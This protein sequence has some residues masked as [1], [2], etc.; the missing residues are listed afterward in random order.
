VLLPLFLLALFGFAIAF[1][2]LFSAETTE[3]ARALSRDLGLLATLA[4][5]A[6]L[7]GLLGTVMGLIRTFR[8]VGSKAADP[9]RVAAGI[10]EALVATEAGLLV[11]L[12][13]VLFFDRLRARAER[14]AAKKARRAE[15][16]EKRHGS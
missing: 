9:A 4:S 1:R 6:P 10:S 5:L 13:L 15:R 7:L 16:E 3:G 2:R 8:A 14:I 12:S 11:A